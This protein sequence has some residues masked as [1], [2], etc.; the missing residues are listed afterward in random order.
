MG[1]PGLGGT[2]LAKASGAA[3]C[4]GFRERRG[5]VTYVCPLRPADSHQLSG[6][7]PAGRAFFLL[8]L[9]LWWLLQHGHHCRHHRGGCGS[10]WEGARAQSLRARLGAGSAS[11]RQPHAPTPAIFH[12]VPC[13]Q[14]WWLLRGGGTAAAEP[15]SSWR[16]R[17]RAKL[18]LTGKP[19]LKHPSTGPPHILWP[20]SRLRPPTSP[21][22]LFPRL[23][24]QPPPLPQWRCEPS[25][26]PG[27]GC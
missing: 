13:L 7:R 8:P 5:L 2:S 1:P 25:A 3:H 4:P 24:R 11:A 9:L 15:A 22:C 10:R 20:S 16:W 26:G 21:P 17:R 6:P 12:L 23:W 19:S 27:G 18:L 14:R